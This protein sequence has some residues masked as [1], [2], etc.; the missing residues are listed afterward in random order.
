MEWWRHFVAAVLPY[1][2]LA[3]FVAGLLYR[4]LYWSRAPKHL[5]WE[6]F[7][8]PHTLGEQLKEMLTEVF[9]LKSLFL[10]NRRAW[11]PSLTMHWG[12]YLLVVWPFLVLAGLP[13]AAPAGKAGGVLALAGSLL[14]LCYR[15]A[16]SEVRRLSAPVEYLNLLFIFALALSGLQSGFLGDAGAVRSYLLG[17]ARFTPEQPPAG[18]LAPV[19]LAELFLIYV[20]LSRMAHFAAKFFTYH[21]V[22]W[23]ELHR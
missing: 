4:V 19:L 11:L 16:R 1:F 20:P 5:H 18:Y 3:F 12:I 22:K 9:T 17:L 7:P 21:K 2:S 8:Y 10:H 6:L 13:L 15:L 14:L 23:G